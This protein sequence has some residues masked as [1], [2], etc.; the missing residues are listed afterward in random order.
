MCVLIG[1]F[2]LQA[3]FDV[4]DRVA[5]REYLPVLPD[6]LPQF[7]DEDSAV[8]MVKLMKN[9]EPLVMR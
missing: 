7:D 6:I 9:N 2:E 4:H 8:K 3:V 1:L 5:N